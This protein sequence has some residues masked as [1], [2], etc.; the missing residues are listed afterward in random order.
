MD[1]NLAVKQLKDAGFVTIRIPLTRKLWTVIDVEDGPTV[2]EHRYHALSSR[3]NRF[4][5]SRDYNKKTILLHREILGFGAVQVDHI[6]S[7]TLDN[8]RNNLRSCNNGQNQA[9]QKKLKRSNTTRFKGV[10]RYGKSGRYRAAVNFGGKFI[11][12]G[13]FDDPA[14]AAQAYDEAAPKYF[15]E[16]AVTNEYIKKRE[17]ES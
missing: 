15:G 5:A 7:D 12:L 13:C 4:Y 14:E 8:R 6:N 9:N 16:F 1:D 17:H 2:L 10:Y 11:H 3:R